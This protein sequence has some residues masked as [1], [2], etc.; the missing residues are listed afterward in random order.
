MNASSNARRMVPDR[1]TR[2]VC[3]SK[4]G[5]MEAAVAAVVPSF[6]RP[7]FPSARCACT[8]TRGLRFHSDDSFL[9]IGRGNLCIVEY[10]IG[11]TQCGERGELMP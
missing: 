1:K 7:S 11:N 4:L 5:V 8:F 10:E 6:D 3:R 9:L 2:R